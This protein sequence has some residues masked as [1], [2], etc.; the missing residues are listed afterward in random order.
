MAPMRLED[1]WLDSLHHS[2]FQDAAHSM[3]AVGMLAPFVESL[4]CF[5]LPRGLREYE[6]K[7]AAI[8]QRDDPRIAA[9]DNEFWDPHFAFDKRGRRIA[10]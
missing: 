7:T 3:A 4:F 8:L 10:T 6:E 5:D 2:I 1:E 9:S